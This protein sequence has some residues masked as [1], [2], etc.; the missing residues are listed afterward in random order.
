MPFI[1]SSGS[2]A[3]D[4]L[5]K[6]I[7]QTAHGFTVGQWVYLSGASTYALTDN[8]TVITADSI[9]VVSAVISANQF[10]L[11][12]HGYVSG[13]SGLTAGSAHFLGSTLGTITTT[14]PSSS[15]MRKPV[16]IADTTTSGWVIDRPGVLGAV[17]AEEASRYNAIIY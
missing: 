16:L 14:E 7:T 5:E 17:A 9:G 13:L 3:G 4:K 1:P 11:I 12:A 8:D 15:Q 6:T 2:S 10:T